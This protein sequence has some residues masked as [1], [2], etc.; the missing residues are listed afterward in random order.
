MIDRLTVVLQSLPN[1]ARPLWRRA[2]AATE[3]GPT[4]TFS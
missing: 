2:Q 3:S 4:T 1:I